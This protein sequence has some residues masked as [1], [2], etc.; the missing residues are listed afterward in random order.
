MRGPNRNRTKKEVFPVPKTLQEELS[1]VTSFEKPKSRLLTTDL[2]ELSGNE[3]DHDL[4]ILTYKLSDKPID[5]E[6]VKLSAK[7]DQ[8][9]SNKKKIQVASE[10]KDK[11]AKINCP[12]CMKKLKTNED[13]YAKHINDCFKV[14]EDKSKQNGNPKKTERVIAKVDRYSPETYSGRAYRYLRQCKY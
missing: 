5:K 13:N 2:T 8:P 6:F 14:T 12:Y 3:H 10:N 11:R 1:T 9:E 7:R 4:P